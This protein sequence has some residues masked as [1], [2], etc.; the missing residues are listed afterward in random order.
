MHYKTK[1][2]QLKA[3][4]DQEREKLQQ[5]IVRAQNQEPLGDL[6]TAWSALRRQSQSVMQDTI[7]DELKACQLEQKQAIKEAIEA[8]EAAKYRNTTAKEEVMRELRKSNEVRKVLK[9]YRRR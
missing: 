2:D 7:S 3:L 9:T 5:L 4:W 1:N 8:I 6:L